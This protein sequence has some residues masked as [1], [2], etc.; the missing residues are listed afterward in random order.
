MFQ[1]NPKTAEMGKEI[2][3][4]QMGYLPEF[5]Q[6]KAEVELKDTPENRQK[7]LKVLKELMESEFNMKNIQKIIENA[8]L[9][10]CFLNCCFYGIVLP[11]CK[12]ML[13]K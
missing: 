13:L 11:S 10:Y 12:K 7:G 5:F 2:L 3:P 6:R 8:L 9:F 1:R 4:F